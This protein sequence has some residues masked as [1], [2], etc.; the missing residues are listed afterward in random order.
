MAEERVLAA[1]GRPLV[2]RTSAFLGPWDRYNFGWAVASALA[3]GE[4]FHADPNIRVSPTYVPDLCHATLDLLVDGETG[5]WHLANP[6]EISWFDLAIR[7]ADGLELH[8][9]L[10]RPIDGSAPALTALTSNRGQLLRP[11][12]AALGDY[13]AE[14]R[15]QF[16]D[17]RIL[18]AAE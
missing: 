10:V 13:L 9:G 2:V 11:F 6:G 16:A 17:D 4:P 5:L 8:R 18:A 7:V 12:E 15:G 14:L 1:G 3:R